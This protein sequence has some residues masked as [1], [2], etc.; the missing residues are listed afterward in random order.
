MHKN[1]KLFSFILLSIILLSGTVSVGLSEEVF[2]D[3]KDK[4]DKKESTTKIIHLGYLQLAA[5]DF[6][7]VDRG[8]RIN[9]ETATEHENGKLD[10][11]TV[12]FHPQGGQCDFKKSLLE[13]DS[14]ALYDDNAIANGGEIRSVENIMI[15]TASAEV[16]E[17]FLKSVEKHGEEKAY[18]KTLKFYHKQLKKAYEESFHLKFPK[19]QD[20]EVTNLHNLAVRAG[21]DFLPAE[22]V[23][24]GELT[25]LFAIDPLGEKLN[26]KEKKQPS[27]PV[28][29]TF[30]EEFTGIDFCPVPP[31]F[32]IQV[33]LLL[34]DQSFGEQFGLGADTFDEF[35]IE[36]ED[37]KFNKKDQVSILLD[38]AFS[39]GINLD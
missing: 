17:K 2:A 28:D 10:L 9:P 20:G 3:K 14:C 16:G 29:G 24:N 18:E 4:K 8:D 33:D 5:H 7:N 39:R 25:S 1:L 38:E 15:S 11:S 22:I 21:H 32:C 26:K 31:F 36:L 6:F 34:A 27:S 37:G 19:P 13:E 35:M 30:D 12:L 23:F